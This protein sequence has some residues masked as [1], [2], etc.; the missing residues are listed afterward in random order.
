MASSFDRVARRAAALAPAGLVQLAVRVREVVAPQPWPWDEAAVRLHRMEKR[1]RGAMPYPPYLYGLV[2]AAR[3]ARAIGATA[4]TA[5][6][7]GVAGGNGLCALE[8]YA[9]DIRRWYGVEV[10]VVGL[11]S[12][13][14]LLPATDPRDCAHALHPGAFAMNEDKLRARLRQAE[15]VIG[16]VRD[17]SGPLMGRLE[18]GELP[19]LGFVSHDLDVYTGTLAALDAMG[20]LGPE[21]ALPR[22]PMYFDDLTGYPYTTETGERAAIDA[23]NAKRETRRI[24][25]VENLEKT[26]GGSSRFATWPRHIFILHAFDHP[27]YNKPE[28]IDLPDLSLRTDPRDPG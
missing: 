21:R 9:E 4:F 18:S 26:L 6:E 13:A 1:G 23:F 5:L 25:Q 20:G 24:G 2:A 12:G 17:T 16:D 14:G 11:D 28:A 7:F 27:H 8:D 3:T 10:R 19:P 22:V 15:L